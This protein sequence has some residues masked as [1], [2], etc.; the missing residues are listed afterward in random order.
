[1]VLGCSALRAAGL[2]AGIFAMVI[3][4]CSTKSIFVEH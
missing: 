1:M 4:P 2:L 3:I